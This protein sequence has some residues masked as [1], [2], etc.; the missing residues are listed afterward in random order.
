MSEN[1]DT[2]VQNASET[3]PETPE[4]VETTE[5]V[6]TAS[7]KATRKAK[8]IANWR[9]LEP[10]QN[11]LTYMDAVLHGTKG[12]KFGLCGVRIEGN[13]QFIDAVLSNLQSLLDAETESTR[14]DITRMAVKPQE[15][16]NAGQNAYGDAEVMY[17]RMSQRGTGKRGRPKG[18]KN[19]PKIVI[20]EAKDAPQAPETSND[21]TNAEPA[22]V[23]NA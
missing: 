12:S 16:Y 6:E 21:S 20:V 8:A 3:L 1:A 4:T 11:P 22:D 9:A 2:N 10:N 19:K 23:A 5:T 15:G 7:D 14:L 17:I 18:S 13:S